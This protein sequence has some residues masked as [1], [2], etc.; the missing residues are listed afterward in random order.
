MDIES[1]LFDLSVSDC[2]LPGEEGHRK[3]LNELRKLC[4]EACSDNLGNIIAPV[5]PTPA[6]GEHILIDAHLD[7]IGFVVTT[8]DP[9][10]FLRVNKVGGPDMR[11]LLGHE[12]TVHGKKTLYGVFCCQPPHLTSRADYKKAAEISE[13]AID[14]GLS[15]D[16]AC[17]LVSPGDT[18][19]LRRNP[20]KMLG[21]LVTGKAFDNRA[22]VVSILRCIDLLKGQKPGAGLSVI[23]S[24]SEETSF[25]A[26]SGGTFAV[27]PTQA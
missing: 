24:L 5:F 16:K 7:E 18:V 8:I 9:D 13:I 10:G 27:A 1:L 15:H 20:A 26:V 12:V 2:M 11:T 25:K 23:F 6:G 17:E 3:A 14:V 19:F 4:P 22:G 21:G